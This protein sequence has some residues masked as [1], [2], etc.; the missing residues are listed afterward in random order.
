MFPSLLVSLSPYV[1]LQSPDLHL[2]T[3]LVLSWTFTLTL[4]NSSFY[5]SLPLSISVCR[6]LELFVVLCLRV[7][8][9]HPS[10]FIITAFWITKRILLPTTLLT[11][12]VDFDLSIFIC[13]NIPLCVSFFPC[14]PLSLLP[15]WGTNTPGLLKGRTH[16]K[17]N[18][19]KPL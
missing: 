15:V 9:C 5:M 18:K 10:V 8:L 2:S 14:P 6:S 3:S 7:Y 17:L 1:C 12:P 4:F 19:V 13:V 16:P 11:H